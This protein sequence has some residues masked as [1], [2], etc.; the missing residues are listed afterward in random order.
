MGEGTCRVIAVG[1]IEP[2]RPVHPGAAAGSIILVADRALR[3][4]GGEVA[5][6]SVMGE[7]ERV[8]AGLGELGYPDI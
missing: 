6:Q 1:H 8:A 3:G 7:G 4:D 5:A 2:V